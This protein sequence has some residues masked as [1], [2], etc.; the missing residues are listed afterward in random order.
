MIARIDISINNAY[1]NSLLITYYSQYPPPKSPTMK[2][3]HTILLLILLITP[4]TLNVHGAS[5]TCNPQDKKTLLKIKTHFGPNALTLSNWDPKTDCC[6][7][8]SV[9][10]FND[11]APGRVSVLQFDDTGISGDIPV[12]I[13]DLPYLDTLAFQA[14]NLTGS[15]P[16]SI[17][18]LTRLQ[19]L[20]I[21]T[22]SL[23]G[24]I[25]SFLGQIKS[26]LK[27]QLSSNPFS[28][29]IPSSLGYLPN[30]YTLVLDGY[31]MLTFF[32]SYF[33]FM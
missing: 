33:A 28:G 31:V 25:P 8:Q 13:G 16:V 2:L 24:P 23:K 11:Q 9:G 20:D 4:L 15:I 27:L 26:L 32:F 6:L 19:E 30:L 1:I 17:T 14:L 29:S 21:S 5:S 12:E 3:H 18:K 10:C 22:T 7:W